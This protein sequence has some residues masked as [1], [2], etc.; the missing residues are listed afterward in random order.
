MR[1]LAQSSAEDDQPKIVTSAS[2]TVQPRRSQEAGVSSNQL[3]DLRSEKK[4]QRR[5][6]F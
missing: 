3:A 1:S 5:Q 4:S 2:H 6:L